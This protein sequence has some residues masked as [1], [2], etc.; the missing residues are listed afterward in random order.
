MINSKFVTTLI[1]IG[2]KLSKYKEGNYVDPSYFKSLVGSLRY[3]TC[4]RPN[5]LF[6]VGLVSRFMESPTTTYLKVAKRIL[7]YLKDTLDY[8][9]FYSSSKEFELEGYMIVTGLE[10]LMIEKALVDMFS[11]LGNSTVIH[12]DNKSTIALAKNLVFHDRSK[13]IDTR[14]H[15]IRD[16]ILRKKVQ[17]EYVKTE[18]Q[19]ADNF[20]KSLKVNVFNKSRTLLGVFQKT[21]LREDV[22]N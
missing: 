16:C 4:T 10:I 6:S 21:C 1:E 15:Y 9:L 7:R 18:D 19:I 17:V 13:H 11:S 3:L 8:G 2:T 5:I 12:V 22:K 20:T 14:F